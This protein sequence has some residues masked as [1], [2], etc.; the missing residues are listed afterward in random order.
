MYFK[1]SI[2]LSIIFA[3]AILVSGNVQGKFEQQ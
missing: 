1:K 3:A 2:I